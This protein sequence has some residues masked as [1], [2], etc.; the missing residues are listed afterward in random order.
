VTVLAA[1]GL[2]AE[3]GNPMQAASVQTPPKPSR[4]TLRNVVIGASA[5]LIG[6]IILIV[7][8]SI[9][10]A[11]TSDPQQA[12]SLMSYV[13]DVISILLTTVMIL[14][15][16]GIAV[17]ILQIARFVNLLINEV[18]PITED[19]KRA[20][21]HAAVAAEFASK[22]GIEPIIKTQ[23]FFFGLAAF[24]RE[25]LRLNKVLQSRGRDD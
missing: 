18:K 17:L 3:K 16:V 5:L 9:F 13:R 7:I 23:A 1:D 15:I 6:L 22:Q 24:F 21:K 14:I 2:R 11:L 25:I 10:I 12:S 4:W 19:T 20:V 8:G